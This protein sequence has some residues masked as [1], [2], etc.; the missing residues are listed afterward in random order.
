MPLSTGEKLGPYE[1]LSAIGAGGMGE[2]YKARDTRLDRTVAVKVL[3]EHIAQREDLRARFE[4]EARAVASLNHP[5]ICTLHDIGR[6]SDISYMVLELIEG[7]T[8]A[9]RIGK[10]ALPLDQA[11]K[12]AAQ[13]ADALDRAHRAG[14]THR[15]VKPQNIML[16]RDGVKV[17]DFGLAK[18][19]STPGP[20]EATLTNVLTTEGTVMG[21]PQYMAPEQFAGKEADARSDTWAF[22][23]VLYE[24]VTGRKAFG[25]QNYSSLVGAILATDPA[26]LAVQPFTPSWLEHLVRRCLAKDPE[27]RW[28]SMRDVVL[29]LRTPPREPVVAAG[30]AKA[31]LWPWALACA[32]VLGAAAWTLFHR[33]AAMAPSGV[34]NLEVSPP[35]GESLYQDAL[36]G[37]QAISPDGRTLAFLAGSKGVRSV[38]LRPLDSPVARALAGTELADGVFWSPDSRH[39]G[40]MAGN[41]LYRADVATGAIKEICDAGN[42]LRG[43]SWSAAGVVL[44]ATVS[45]PLRRVPADGGAPV[46]V[47]AFYRFETNQHFPQFLPDGKQFLYWSRSAQADS[48][49][50]YSGALDRPPE[51]QPRKKLLES[52]ISA[53]YAPGPGASTGYL[54]FRRGRSVL[55]QPL[56]PRGMTLTGQPR[57]VAENVGMRAG[58]GQYSVSENGILATASTGDLFRFVSI[59]SP[60]GATISTVGKP[61]SYT[62]LR[63]S[64][65]ARSVALTKLM[66]NAAVEIWL[67]D[68]ARGLPVPFTNNASVSLSPVWSLRGDEIIYS[69]HRDGRYQMY[70]KPVSGSGREELVAPTGRPQVVNDWNRI[71]PGVVYRSGP[72]TAASI[73]LLPLTP[74]GKPVVI[75]DSGVAK[76]NARVSPSGRWLAY[77]SDESGGF[78]VFVRSMPEGDRPAGSKVRVSTAGGMNPAWSADGNT[79]FFNSPDDR[80]F[81]VKLKISDGRIE[82]GEPKAMFPLGGSSSYMGAIYWEPIGNG[83]RFVVLRSTPTAGRD[84]RINVILNWQAGLR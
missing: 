68:L 24:M 29:E 17:L 73:E 32:A 49:G 82:A 2:V 63:L 21:T 56:D 65:D 44:F 47:T 51:G 41:R 54:L 64:P 12:F 39:L 16:T 55:A 69:V 5:H 23:A 13:V 22:G 37:I 28:Q 3:P 70:R 8:L 38:W 19:A 77:S 74:G 62:A 43:A 59:V 53:L 79:L 46:P 18:S 31:P 50:V 52:P 30:K 78:E 45:G 6:Q 80:L 25:G 61:D 36:S 57:P 40:F 58:L 66:P 83:E 11:L 35:D 76:S 60:D 26:P 42:T 48:T 27:D 81:S 15:D 9:A 72:F 20:A 34:L 7:E 10:G 14:V 33:P 4:R 75:D 71:P 67:M 84:N 1:I